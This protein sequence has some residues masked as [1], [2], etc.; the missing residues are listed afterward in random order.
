[1]LLVPLVLVP[2]VIAYAFTSYGR[3]PA[4]HLPDYDRL[5]V[6]G[7]AVTFAALSFYYGRK[8]NAPLL[9]AYGIYLI[10]LALLIWWL[11]LTPTERSGLLMSGAGGPLAV[12]GAMRLRAA[13]LGH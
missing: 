12:F 5:I 11:P 4:P 10:C 6:P 13:D 8:R 7:F 2:L 1:M 3:Q 9:L